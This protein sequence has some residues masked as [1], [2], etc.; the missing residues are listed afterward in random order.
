MELTKPLKI[1]KTLALIAFALMI[2][3]AIYTIVTWDQVKFDQKFKKNNKTT[4]N[5]TGRCNYYND[6]FF[7]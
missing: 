6:L 2:Y 7:L 3:G 1:Q 5:T 4:Q